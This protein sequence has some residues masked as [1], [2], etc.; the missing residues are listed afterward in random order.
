MYMHFL[1]ATALLCGT[2]NAANPVQVY[3]LMGQSNM[4]GM[5]PLLNKDGENGALLS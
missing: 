2:T 3:I 4:L 5:A 1:A